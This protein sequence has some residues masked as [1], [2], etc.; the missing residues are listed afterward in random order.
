MAIPIKK[1]GQ[2]VL[3]QAHTKGDGTTKGKLVFETDSLRVDFDVRSIKGWS[4]AK[5]VLYNLAP[6]VVKKLSNSGLYITVSI[7]QHDSPLRIVMYEMYVSNALEE[8][9]VPDSVTSLYCFSKIRK[10]SLEIDIDETVIRPSLENIVRQI[11][12][13]AGFRGI[14]EYKHF[15]QEVLDYIP[16]SP[17][18]RQRGTLQTC[19]E[20]LGARSA[21]NF[22]IYTEG[23][24]L[25]LMY[26]PVAKNVEATGLFTGSGDIVLSTRNMRSNPKIGPATLSVVSN[27]DP[28]IRPASVL[29]I[30]QL[31]T[32]STSAD[33]RTL[34]VIKDYLRDKVAGFSK[35]QAL[36]VQHKGSNWTAEWFTQVAATSPSIGTDMPTDKWFS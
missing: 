33:D 31:L 24:N 20:R 7:S 18:S 6:D 13:A 36:S 29:D 12:T 9:R 4:R 26:K 22:N 15:P 19:L 27:L 23:D 5:V 8:T 16:P 10:D 11:T 25:V 35:Y 21:Y 17:S 2:Y 14:V 28:D 3:F 1:F 34:A 30:S 32:A